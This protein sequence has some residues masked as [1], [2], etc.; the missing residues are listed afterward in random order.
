M[1]RLFMIVSAVLLLPACSDA[2]GGGSSS[3]ADRLSLVGLLR[4]VPD[5]AKNRGMPVFY[6]NLARVRQGEHASSSDNDIS[7]LFDRSSRS[8]FLPNPIRMGI[9]RPEFAE[10]AGFDSRAIDASL[11]FG[12]F[13]DSVAILVGTM[14]AGDV[15]KG[16]AASPGGDQLVKENA[17]GVSYFSLGNDDEIDLKGVSA[18]RNVGQP[19]RMALAG[20]TLYWAGTRASIDA[21]VAVTGGTAKS[22]AD[23][24]DY[25][26]TALA[27]DAA[28]VVNGILVSPAAGESWITAGLGETFD[29]ESSTLTIALRYADAATATTAATA[30]RAHVE[31]DASIVTR[32]PWAATL[33][34]T[35]VQTDGPLLVGT[36]TSKSPG[37]ATRVVLQR[38]DLLQF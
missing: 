29:G 24:A 32:A 35:D 1:K 18:I 17:G 31:N 37:I 11:E 13:P 8:L 15:Q 7:L 26:A 21:C 3:T 6:S 19:L 10:F 36:L 12:V 9:F 14:K 5:T 38:D 20:D 34:V 22:L 23:D 2:K 33:T 27:L 4:S 30:F 28:A 25:L 16:L